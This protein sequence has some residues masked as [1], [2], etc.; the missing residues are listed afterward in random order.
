MQY[1]RSRKTFPRRKRVLRK[2]MAPRQSSALGVAKKA[3]K[4]AASVANSTT[5]IKYLSWNAAADI[6]NNGSGVWGAALNRQLTDT[7]NTTALFGA[8]G[9]TGNKAFL[10][11]V[12]GTWTIDMANEEE[13]CN[14]TVAVIKPR[15]DF[16]TVTGA[17]HASVIQGQ[18]YFDPKMWKVLYYKH[19]ALYP[20]GSLSGGQGGPS[21]M[22]GKFYIPV[23]KMVRFV[24]EGASGEQTNTSPASWQDRLYFVVYTDNAQLDAENPRINCRTL[25]V[26]RDNDINY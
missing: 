3:L 10:K 6:Y 16:D 1:K 2:R 4:L 26:Y 13:A 22:Y 7:N 5:E 12:K 8:D 23:K 25:T 20:G 17:T 18:A 9:L 24:N 19:F 14:F 15:A 21:C 11:Y